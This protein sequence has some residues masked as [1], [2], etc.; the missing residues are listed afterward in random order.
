M[1][2]IAASGDIDV[3]ALTDN[4]NLL[5]KLNITQTA[6]RIVIS[7]KEEIVIN[8]GG[9]YIKLSGSAIELGTTGIFT[10]HAA[11]HSLPGPQNMSVDSTLAAARFGS[12]IASEQILSE[13]VAIKSWVEFKLLDQDGPIPGERFVLTDSSGEKHT[14]KV[15]DEGTARLEKIPIGRCKVEFPDLGYLLEVATT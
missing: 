14:G 4:V 1:K 7:A 12:S 10:A 2:L 11:S 5:A 15:D 13:L 9:S 6:N 3:K 8:G